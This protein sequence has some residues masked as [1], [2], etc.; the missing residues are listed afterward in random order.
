MFSSVK[1]YTLSILPAKKKY[2]Q[3]GW[4]SFN[5][6][7]CTHNGETADTRGR[8]GIIVNA[9]SKIS[10]SCFNCK[11]KT[12][13]TPG[14]ILSFKFRKFLFWLGADENEIQR[15]IIE[16]V[17]I[18]ELITPEDIKD[19]EEI[20]F[21]PRKLPET[22]LTLTEWANYYSDNVENTVH[23]DFMEALNYIGSRAINLKNYD[24]YWSPD[25]EERL[26]RRIIIPFVYKNQIV[27]YTARAIDNSI[28]PKYLSNT[29][30]DFV[31][32]LDRQAV[33]N[34]FVIVS[35][36]PMD[37]MSLDAVSIQGN[38]IS[39]NQAEL[40]ESLGKE[41]IVVPD[42]DAQVNNRGRSVWSGQ[43]TIEQAMEFGWS[44][45]FPVW[46]ETCKDI[47]AAVIKYGKLFTLKAILDSRESN[48]LKIKLLSKK[49]E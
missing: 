45:S 42:F 20:S 19:Q 16:S 49:Y 8:G 29:P 46:A 17:R 43:R 30:S 22:A 27:G 10:Y 44:V 9:D 37:A 25:T 33:N 24:F 11:F 3:G 47:N 5:A 15:L 6:V 32:N 28:K 26:N 36:G 12:S 48:K 40:I 38:E 39:D 4:I 35:E 41:V 31:F 7:C 14:R 18:K 1:D 23:S 34:K 2:T 13:Y 21:E